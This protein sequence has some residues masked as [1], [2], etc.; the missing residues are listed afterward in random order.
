MSRKLSLALSK[1]KLESELQ[2]L[3]HLTEDFGRLIDQAA[4][5]RQNTLV[6]GEIRFKERCCGRLKSFRSAGKAS[7]ALA[8]IL[9]AAC[10]GHSQ[11]QA[12]LC[13]D[14]DLG[15]HVSNVRFKLRY[16]TKSVVDDGGHGNPPWIDIESDLESKPPNSSY[17]TWARSASAQLSNTDPRQREGSVTVPSNVV[18]VAPLESRH[19]SGNSTNE[20]RNSL[21]NLLRNDDVCL[22]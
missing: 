12:I 22:H 1:S 8:D 5:L 16:R 7:E 19:R 15:E 9:T 13:L 4:T 10:E 14:P 11:H 2:D 3:R 18:S 21:S 20:A 6:H 17:S